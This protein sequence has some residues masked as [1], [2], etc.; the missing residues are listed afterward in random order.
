MKYFAWIIISVVAITVIAGFFIVGS[1]RE[2][3]L[4]R[5]DDRRVQ[6]LQILQSEIIN[7]WQLKRALPGT[8]DMLKDDIRGFAPPVDPES[9]NP[10]EYAIKNPLVFELCA[11]FNRASAATMP[12]APK[13]AYPYGGEINWEHGAGKA[14]FERTIDKDLYPPQKPP[15]PPLLFIE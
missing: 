3:R 5:F 10:Y 1:P 9:G 2:E 11:V 12:S 15:H 14:C 6:D 7:Y 4:R 13:R 8:A